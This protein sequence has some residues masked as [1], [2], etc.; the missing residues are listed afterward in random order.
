MNKRIS[1]Y[2]LLICMAF[3]L[4]VGGIYYPKW[5]K[6][7]TEATISWDVSGYYFYLPAVF[8]YKDIHQV[9]FRDSIHQKY[10]PADAP[11]QAFQHPSGNYVMKYS[12]GLAVQYLPFFLIAHALAPALGYP[13]DGFSLPYQAAISWG[14]L[15]VAFLGLWLLRRNLLRHFSDE[16]TAITLLLIVFGTNYL[17]YSA[18]NGAMTHNYLFTLYAALV[19]VTAS[20]YERPTLLKALGIGFVVGLAALTRPTEILTALIPLLWGVANAEDLQKRLGLW[21]KHWLQMAGAVVVCGL[22]GSFQLLYWKMASGDWIVYSYEDQGFSWLK[23]HIDR[24]VFSFRAGWLVYTPMMAFAVL[25]FVWL[26]KK[27]AAL[28]P[29]ILVFFLLFLYVTF[30]WDIWWYGG[31][32]GQRAMVQS[33]AVLA[34]P[35]AAFVE[36]LKDR[37]TLRYVVFAIFVLFSYYNLWLTHQ[38]HKGGMLEPG[39]MTKAYWK[40]IV[41]RYDLPVETRKLLDTD[42]DYGNRRRNV[43]VIYENN[44]ETAELWADCPIPPIEGSRSA[45]IGGGR[46]FT[47]P[48]GFELP[49]NGS[50][51]LRAV[52]TMRSLNKEWDTWK[53]AQLIVRVKNNDE[54]VHERAIR[55]FR[56]LN[57]NETKE[58]YLDLR[59]PDR[60]FNR[61]EVFFWNADSDKPLAID[62]L[63]VERFD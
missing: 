9:A 53:M 28:F 16:A 57:D 22:M 23:P 25:G 50:R 31:S 11:Y 1:L 59:L 61:A 15:L 47:E 34:F 12:C 30:A 35:L 29:A 42:R 33:Y 37:K 21:K 60:P 18:I 63:R 40:R 62:Q 2:S 46:Q 26:Y 56:L 45:C 55:V 24:G 27:H 41:L 8:I 6:G 3:L 14:S 48:F 4:A 36:W 7:Q 39:F 58:I 19:A 54:A 20:W 51:K 10:R 43:Q 5:N 44:F 17:D 49:A 32:L 38:A 13:A 52:V